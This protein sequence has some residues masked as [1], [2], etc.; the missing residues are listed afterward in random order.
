MATPGTAYP[1]PC[2]T[3]GTPTLLYG[4]EATTDADGAILE[5][6]HVLCTNPDHPGTQNRA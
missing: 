5:P 4:A 2:A 1:D 3:C 6:Q